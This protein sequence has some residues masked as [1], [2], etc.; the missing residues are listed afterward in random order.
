[1]THIGLIIG[2]ICQMVY[3][4]R[5]VHLIRKWH[6]PYHFI[7]WGLPLCA[8]I[9]GF[10]GTVRLPARSH[11]RREAE[12]NLGLD[13]VISGRSGV[14]RSAGHPLVLLAGRRVVDM[15]ALLLSWYAPFPS[16]APNASLTELTDGSPSCAQW[17]SS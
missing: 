8:V 9:A 16:L 6:I 12:L 7:A 1:M 13:L 5:S 14:R 3:L 15:G 11:R 10:A 17:Q 2:R 4:R